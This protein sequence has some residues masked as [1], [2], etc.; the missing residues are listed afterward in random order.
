MADCKQNVNRHLNS[1]QQWLSEAEHAFNK[2]KDI[3]G[4]LNLFLAQAELTHAREVHRS[5]QWRFKYP[6]LRHGLALGLAVTVAVCGVG[7]SYWWGINRPH[8][9]PVSGDQM[10]PA[11]ETSS[12]PVSPALKNITTPDS[13]PP[14]PP[15]TAT[16]QPSPVQSQSAG[17]KQTVQA[18]ESSESTE[19]K[20][21]AA[22]SSADHSKEAPLTTDEINKL[23]RTAGQSLRG[24]Q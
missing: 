7:V 3:R 14:S 19:Q 13:P 21:S 15:A 17:Y 2:D 8:V 23:I 5:R 9:Q 10:A 12:V 1:A 22:T 6:I 20:K 11:G 18:S 4:E 24:Q 16:V